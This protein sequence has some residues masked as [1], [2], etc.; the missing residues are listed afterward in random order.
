MVT[1]LHI[2]EKHLGLC[3]QLMRSKH[4][5]YG[6]LLPNGSWTG[7]MGLL[8]RQ[9]MDCSGTLFTP[10][11]ER[12]ATLDFSEAIYLDE[13]NVMYARPGV[14]PDVAGFIKPYTPLVSGALPVL[15]QPEGTTAIT[16]ISKAEL[17]AQ[18]ICKNST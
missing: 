3:F 18:T 2:I 4:R 17:S 8:Q 10:T 5:E 6:R 13:M 15:F 14:S 11:P 1:I 9:E 16:S 7:I 12:I